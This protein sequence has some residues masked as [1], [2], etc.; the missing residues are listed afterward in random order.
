MRFLKTTLPAFLLLGAPLVAQVPNMSADLTIENA[1]VQMEIALSCTFET[2]CFE[3]E[4]CAASTYMFELN[5]R[6]GGLTDTEM[7]VQTELVSEIGDTRLIGAR[8]GE[9]MS[10]AG[11]TFEARHLLTLAAD[12]AARYTLHY[13]EGPMVISYLGEC[14]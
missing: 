9:A 11:G 10:L 4:S 1:P 12:G 5:G 14:K 2:E 3:S 8:S 6:A 13:A 7:V